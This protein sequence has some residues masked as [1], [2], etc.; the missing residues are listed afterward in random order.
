MCEL[1]AL[2]GY[3]P[4]N[5]QFFLPKFAARGGGVG[6]H[7]DGW[8]IAFYQDRATLVIR[9]AAPAW[10]SELARFVANQTIRSATV[11]T[12]IR[13]ATGNT[14]VALRNTQPFVRELAGREHVFAHNGDVRGVLS[15]GQFSL[16]HFHPIGETDS[17]H[18]FCYL[19][20]QLDPLWREGAPAIEDRIG[21]IRGVA[22]QLATLGPFNFL[23]GDGE[24]LYAYGHRRLHRGKPPPRPP[25][26]HWVTHTCLPG[27]SELRGEGVHIRNLD[28]QQEQKVILIAS[29]PLTDG[30]WQPLEEGSLLILRDGSLVS[31]HLKGQRHD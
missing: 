20:D 7:L 1:F 11:I 30:P 13:K 17:E 19:L 16:K 18:A 5:V 9:E 12:H 28:A 22:D 8:G 3:C 10:N 15:E 23:Y 21:V 26:L 6:P 2:S 31:M 24:Y 4:T 27:V 29:V 25:G 14:A